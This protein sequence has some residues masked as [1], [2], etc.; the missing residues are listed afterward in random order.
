MFSKL[1]DTEKRD[2]DAVRS[3]LQKCFCVSRSEA[4]CL[5]KQRQLK[6]DESREVYV[7]DLCRLLEL[8]G[9]KSDSETD[10]VVIEQLLAGRPI[11]FAKDVRLSIAVRDLKVS[12]CLDRIQALRSATGT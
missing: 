10:P 1:S 9:H 11:E 5:F 7:A 3:I 12:E 8:S 4:Y 2:K 6:V